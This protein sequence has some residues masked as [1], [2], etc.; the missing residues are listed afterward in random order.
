MRLRHQLLSGGNMKL[1]QGTLLYLVV[2]LIVMAGSGQAQ[3]D[4][5]KA[6]TGEGIFKANCVLCH[7][8][9][10]HS[11]TPLGKQLGAFD[12]HSPEV[13]K[14][15]DA[16][17]NAVITHGEKSMPAFGGQISAAEIGR[18]LSYVRGFGKKK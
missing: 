4:A 5:A 16:A 18:V 17:L 15:S 11:Q 14:K 13:Q 10:G 9:D 3:D 7:G 6:S 12:L 8:S 2:C 1:G